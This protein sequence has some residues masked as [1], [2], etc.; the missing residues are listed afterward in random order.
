MGRPRKLRPEELSVTASPDIKGDNV[1]STNGMTNAVY[2]EKKTR[3]TTLLPFHG[4]DSLEIGIPR[5]I[6]NGRKILKLMKQ[7][8]GVDDKGNPVYTIKRTLH[9]TIFDHKK[10]GQILRSQLQKM[11]IPGA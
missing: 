8:R 11:G 4:K 2:E 7:Q 1:N 6:V 5:F 9:K 3:E 10:T